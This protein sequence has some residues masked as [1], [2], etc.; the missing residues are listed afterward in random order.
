M[1]LRLQFQLNVRTIHPDFV[2]AHPMRRRRAE[3]VARADL[4]LGAMPGASDLVALELPSERGP[5]RCVQV[6]SMAWNL[7]STLN[8]AIFFPCT[9]TNLPRLG[10]SSLA[11]ATLTYSAM[12]AS[13]FT[14]CGREFSLGPDPIALCVGI[15]TIIATFDATK[16][17]NTRFRLNILSAIQ[18]AA[19]YRSSLYSASH[20]FSFRARS[21]LCRKCLPR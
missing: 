10:S 19:V 12:L 16:P 6:L 2:A 17:T 3:H 20:F 14:F 4:E 9:S 13:R 11:C 7:P 1:P 8:R 21:F 15:V 5:P 18:P